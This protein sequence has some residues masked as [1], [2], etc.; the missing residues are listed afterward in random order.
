MDVLVAPQHE[1]RMARPR[2]VFARGAASPLRGSAALG[3]LRSPSLRLTPK[4]RSSREGKQFTERNLHRQGLSAWEMD[5]TGKLQEIGRY[6]SQNCSVQQVV[7]SKDRAWAAVENSPKLEILGVTNPKKI[8]AVV[9]EAGQGLFYG[10][11]IPPKLTPDGLL[12]VIWHMG[13]P[14]CYDFQTLPP[15]RYSPEKI[16]GGYFISTPLQRG[17]QSGSA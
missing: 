12:P 9:S 3:S 10:K 4:G 8:H 11:T 5:G 7:L 13:G 14:V 1:T 17:G 6:K 15:H 2:P 16:F